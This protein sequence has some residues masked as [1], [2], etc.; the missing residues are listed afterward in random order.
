MSSKTFY[1][2]SS[3]HVYQG[4]SVNR[5]MWTV[6]ACLAPAAIWGVAI[7]GIRSLWVLLASTAAA[8]LTEL[9]FN[10][11][12]GEN[13]LADGSAFLTGFLVG[14]NMPPAIPGFVPIVGSIFAIAVVKQTF[15]GLGRN[16]MNPALAARV[17]LGEPG[18]RDDSLAYEGTPFAPGPLYNVI[19]A[20][21]A[22]PVLTALLPGAP[23]P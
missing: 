21:A 20:A 9:V 2:T 17:Y 3:P 13:T 1:L 19:T 14:L 16:W 12:R 15:G 10:R 23:P 4:D 5:I 8:M 6:S 18:E 7:F 22:L 11:L